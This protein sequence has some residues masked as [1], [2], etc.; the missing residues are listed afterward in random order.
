DPVALRYLLTEP[1]FTV[2]PD[3]GT[4]SM[5][6]PETPPSVD[7][8]F[9]GKNGR[10]FLFLVDDRQ[11]QWMSTAALDAFSKTLAALKLSADDV[12]LLNLATRADRVRKADML[13][14]FKPAVIVLLGIAPE[15]VGLS[16]SSTPLCEYEGIKLFCTCT[17]DE[18][19]VE[20]EKKRQFWSTIKTLLT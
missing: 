18:M 13:S 6:Q 14:F 2:G 11:H 7:F 9:Y 8:I 5:D 12:A 20:A 16:M 1:I 4:P 15:A 19:L 17:F 10:R 3:K